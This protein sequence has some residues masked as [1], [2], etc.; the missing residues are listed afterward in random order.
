[1]AQSAPLA[2]MMAIFASIFALTFASI[3][4]FAQRE[5]CGGFTDAPVF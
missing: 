1:L 3:F 4:A 5:D 2:T